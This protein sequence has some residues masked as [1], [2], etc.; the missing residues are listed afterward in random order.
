MTA[1]LAACLDAWLLAGHCRKLNVS[2]INSSTNSMRVLTLWEQSAW[3]DLVPRFTFSNRPFSSLVT[4]SH[5]LSLPLACLLTVRVHRLIVNILWMHAQLQTDTQTHT[6]TTRLYCCTAA[7][8]NPR[9]RACDWFSWFTHQ[10]QSKRIIWA[11]WF[12][13]SEWR[14]VFLSLTFQGSTIIKQTLRECHRGE[15]EGTTPH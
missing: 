5:Y 13:T 1:G 8:T 3:D 15:R 12:E 11:T 4:V 7:L 2:T 6:K 9:S 14:D 10:P